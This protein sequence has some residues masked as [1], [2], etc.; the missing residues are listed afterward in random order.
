M[1]KAPAQKPSAIYRMIIGFELPAAK[2]FSLG[3]LFDVQY[4]CRKG[5]DMRKILL[6]II[7]VLSLGACAVTDAK[8]FTAFTTENIMKLYV[9]M[10]S[11]DV[12]GLFGTPQ[13]I[14]VNS[15]GKY[16]N[17]WTCTTW[18][19]GETLYSNRASFT[20]AGEHGELLLNN[21]DVDRD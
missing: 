12:I 13:D 3:S 8:S 6:L 14:S 18:K 1:S 17:Q 21:F 11:D 4:K 15:C 20:F 19:Y 7:T 9:G 16:P 2:R 5:H 10:P